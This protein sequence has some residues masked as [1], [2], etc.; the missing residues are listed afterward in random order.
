MINYDKLRKL[1]NDKGLKYGFI[2]NKLGIT[3]VSLQ[4]K[5]DGI[6]DFKLN[7]VRILAEI[8]QLN[9]KKDYKLMSDIFFA[10]HVE[11]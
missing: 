7:E 6:Y 3:V 8:L 4:R 11:K 10:D 9:W 5:L 2:A 1:I